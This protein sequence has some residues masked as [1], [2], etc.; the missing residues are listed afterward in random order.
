MKKKLAENKKSQRVFDKYIDRAVTEPNV[1]ARRYYGYNV[2]ISGKNATEGVFA[3]RSAGNAQARSLELAA[4]KTNAKFYQGD[5]A[6][7]A[8]VITAGVFVA[9]RIGK[10][11]FHTS[12]KSSDRTAVMDVARR[13]HCIYDMRALPIQAIARDSKNVVHLAF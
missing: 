1:F 10:E 7:C 3:L 12:V 9:V 13:A 4:G 11:I 8:V 6:S 2:F 5:F